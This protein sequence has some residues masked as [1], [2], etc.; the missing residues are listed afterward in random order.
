MVSIGPAD[1]SH[2]KR[3]KMQDR[4]LEER[5]KGRERKGR[6]GFWGMDAPAMK[7]RE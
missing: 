7:V 5:G 2:I 3:V 4:K 1:C 6:K